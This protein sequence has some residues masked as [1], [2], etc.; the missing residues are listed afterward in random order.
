MAQE[1]KEAG[2]AAAGARSGAAGTAVGLRQMAA[3]LAE[4]HDLPRRQVE[5]ILNDFVTAFTDHL[6]A[7]AKVRI[8]GLGV[9]QVRDRP[10]RTGRNPATGEPIQIAASRTIAFRPAKEL[11]DAI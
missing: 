1:E 8:S 11:R 7:G 5:A 2:T 9:F 6:K 10:A 3:A 4:D